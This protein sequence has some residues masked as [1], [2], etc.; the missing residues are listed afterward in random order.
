MYHGRQNRPL[1]KAV[2]YL[3]WSQVGAFG[4]SL[5]ALAMDPVI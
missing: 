1:E 4:W 5:F 3:D 2:I